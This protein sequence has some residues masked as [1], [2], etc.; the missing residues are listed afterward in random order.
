M[1]HAFTIAANSRPHSTVTALAHIFARACRRAWNALVRHSLRGEIAF[2]NRRYRRYRA[3]HER[4]A[5]LERMALFDRATAQSRLHR[6][7]PAATTKE[8]S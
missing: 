3:K 8:M 6:L 5:T 2:H 4:A 1:K 7:Q